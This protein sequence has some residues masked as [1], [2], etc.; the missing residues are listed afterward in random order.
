MFLS[1]NLLM[2]KV[3]FSRFFAAMDSNENGEVDFEE[4]VTAVRQ[5]DPRWHG[6]AE[7]V[8]NATADNSNGGRSGSIKASSGDVSVGKSLLPSAGARTTKGKQTRWAQSL[9]S[10]R[11]NNNKV[12][13]ISTTSVEDLDTGKQVRMPVSAEGVGTDSVENI[14]VR[15][16]TEVRHMDTAR[17]VEDTVSPH[18]DDLPC[19]TYDDVTDVVT[20]SEPCPESAST[21]RA[22]HPVQSPTTADVK[23]AVPHGSWM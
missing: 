12:M 10:F 19:E 14:H 18:C 8:E 2:S 13:D 7:D 23:S 11:R 4:F 3:M 5:S 1:N 22:T 16:D 17:K 15:V 6:A 21:P 20:L 9:F